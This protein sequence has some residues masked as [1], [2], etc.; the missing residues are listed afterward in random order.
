MAPESNM[1]E[2]GP[3]SLGTEFYLHS[4]GWE[5]EILNTYENKRILT[6]EPPQ[7]TQEK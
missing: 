3:T 4:Q 1:L 5:D 2:T 6:S 7:S